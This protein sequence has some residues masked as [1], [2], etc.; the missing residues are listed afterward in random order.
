M[1][2]SILVLVVNVMNATIFLLISQQRSGSSTFEQL[3]APLLHSKNLGEYFTRSG[4]SE[5]SDPVEMLHSECD[6]GI[7]DCKLTTK[8]FDINVLPTAP[9]SQIT[10]AISSCWRL[11]TRTRWSG[12]ARTISRAWASASSRPASFVAPARSRS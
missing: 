8:L 11:P 2:A 1:C 5:L 10:Q 12:P 4:Y 3:L 9:T 7:Q 6:S